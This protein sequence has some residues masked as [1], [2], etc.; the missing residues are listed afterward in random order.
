MAWSQ[1]KIEIELKRKLY[2]EFHHDKALA[3]KYYGYYT[4]ALATLISE[5]IYNSI[6][7]IQKGLSDHGENHIMNVLDNAYELLVHKKYDATT[8]I[9]V[10]EEINSVDAIQL[11]F[12]C[13]L[14]LFH[15]V[16][17]LTSDRKVHHEQEVI[18]QVYNHV[19]KL[20]SEFDDEQVLIPEVAS[21]HSGKA[22]DGSKDTIADLGIYPRHLFGVKIHTKKCA[23]L[24]RFADELAEGSQRTSIFMNKFYDYPYPDGSDIYHKYAEITKIDIDREHERICIR[25]NFILKIVD[26]KIEA[27][28]NEEFIQLF[29]FALRR[30]LKLE[31][32]RK[33]CRYYCD[34]LSPFKRT[35]VTFN[36][37]TE[38]VI[39]SNGEP[40]KLRRRIVPNSEHLNEYFFDDLTLPDSESANTFISKHKEFEADSV[41]TSLKSAFDAK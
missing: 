15:D 20:E 37:F 25:Y 38:E 33:Y 19:R 8:Q 39:V 21:K 6:K 31:A 11:Y 22:L 30:M 7:I 4:K 41:F 36:Y 27:V 14:I 23:A 24:L 3:D 32:E 26:G 13:V 2:A 35:H 29:G 5:D 18:R 12:I 9:L 1:R 40:Q 16:G 17:N 10:S 28:N 34:W